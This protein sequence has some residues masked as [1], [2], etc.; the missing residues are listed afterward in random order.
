MKLLKWFQE[1]LSLS[2]FSGFCAPHPLS[3]SAMLLVRVCVCVCVSWGGFTQPPSRGEKSLSRGAI[4]KWG[5]RA[6]PG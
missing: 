2:D 6:P 3:V 5:K 4:G 1:I